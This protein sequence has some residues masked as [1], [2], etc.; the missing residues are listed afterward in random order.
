VR[1]G[2]VK[3]KPSVRKRPSSHWKQRL[4]WRWEEW[5]NRTSSQDLHQVVDPMLLVAAGDLC[6]GPFA[7]NCCEDVPVRFSVHVGLPSYTEEPIFINRIYFFHSDGYEA[8]SLL[9]IAPCSPLKLNWRFG[10]TYRLHL[11]DRRVNEALLPIF[12]ML[13]SCLATRKVE[14]T[15][16]FETSVD[17]QRSA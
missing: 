17:F 4:K 8:F 16:S 10:G 3:V 6:F 13:V 11:Q 9:D 7:T 15:Y 12:F 1:R 5:W 14:V 2:R